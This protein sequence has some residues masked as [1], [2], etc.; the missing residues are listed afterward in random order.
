MVGNKEKHPVYMRGKIDGIGHAW[1]ASGGTY[2]NG[3]VEY[4]AYTFRERFDFY[5]VYKYV[6][7]GMQYYYFY[8]NWG[9]YGLDDNC[10]IVPVQVP[11]S[12]RPVADEACNVDARISRIVSPCRNGGFRGRTAC[13][14]ERLCRICPGPE[15]YI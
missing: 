15:L 1:I 10:I 3:D 11:V 5:P 13:G 9:W 2:M 6:D 7:S 12:G 4:Y 14:P 8:M